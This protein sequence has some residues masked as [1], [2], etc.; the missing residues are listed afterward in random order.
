MGN[1]K[2]LTYHTELTPARRESV[3]NIIKFNREKSNTVIFL[4]LFVL[5]F[6]C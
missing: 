4:F 5:H 3:I 2:V 6:I 1:G